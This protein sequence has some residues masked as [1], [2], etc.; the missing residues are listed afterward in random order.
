MASTNNK[1]P[2]SKWKI[3]LVSLGIWILFMAGY[4]YLSKMEEY[5]GSVKVKGE[6]IDMLWAGR[7][8]GK[9]SS[10]RYK[11]PQFSFE[12]NDSTYISSDKNMYAK[13]RDIG[14]RVTVI[15]PADMPEEARIYSV[16]TW[17]ISF[18]TLLVSGLLFA[19]LFG[20]LFVTGQYNLYKKEQRQGRSR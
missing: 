3:V 14:D 18:P 17:W 13:T 2:I 16:L 15:F 10:G 11:Y 1:K 5:A 4:F 20:V 6:V 9:Y 8:S 7:G 12:Y 19:M